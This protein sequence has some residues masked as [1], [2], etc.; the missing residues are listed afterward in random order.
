MRMLCKNENEQIIFRKFITWNG[1]MQ[2][3]KMVQIEMH[4]RDG[5]YLYV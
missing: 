5:F 4:N 3:K 2:A 1:A